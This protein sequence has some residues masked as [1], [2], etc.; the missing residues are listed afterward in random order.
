MF[1]IWVRISPS[2]QNFKFK[3]SEKQTPGDIDLLARVSDHGESRESRV[4]DHG[5][6]RESRV[7]DHG[8]SRYKTTGS[9][10]YQTTGSPG[11]KGSNVSATFILLPRVSNSLGVRFFKLKN[12]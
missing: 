3:K 10:G 9:P 1:S 4:S 8:Q 11:S 5:E 7:S 2:F 6:S 12:N